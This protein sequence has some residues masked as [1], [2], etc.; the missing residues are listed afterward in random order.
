[1]IRKGIPPA[2]RCAVWLSNVVQAV[3]PHQES[4]YWHEY[5]T[6][7]KVRAL[8]NAYE[9]LLSQLIGAGGGGGSAAS[10]SD[11]NVGSLHSTGISNHSTSDGHKPSQQQQQQFNDLADAKSDEIWA[12]MD[13]PAFGQRPDAPTVAGATPSGELA[14][15]RV[16]VALE[17]VL[18][19]VDHAPM[20]PTLTSLLLT[21]MSESYAFCAVREMSHQADWYFPV[22]M[23]EHKAWR[24]AFCDVLRKLHQSTYAYLDD[25]CV[26]DDLSPLFQDLFVGVLPIDSVLRMMDIFTLEGA[27]VLFRFGVALLVLY[28]MESA[29]QLITI[30]TASEWWAGL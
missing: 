18:V 23:R 9:G 11:Q 14:R 8:D 16:L 26:L 2:L 22:S 17:R 29:K 25:R 30:S 21:S 1:M 3:H 27:K 7:A 28:K 20:V 15:K 13:A 12:S 5:R 6:L 19:G 4:S 24:R 10:S